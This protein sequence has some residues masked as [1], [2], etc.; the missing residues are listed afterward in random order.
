MR[1]DKLPCE[2][3]NTVH[4]HLL[5]KPHDSIIVAVSGG[6]DS[7]ALITILNS[8]NS[9]KNLNLSLFVAHLNHQLRGKS[10]EEDAQFVKNL[11][12]NLSLPFLLKSVDIQK[13]AD[14]TK[15]SIEE[16]AR[17]ERYKFF[18]ESAQKH[19]ACAIA[20]G[21]TADDNTETI[22]HRILRGT[23]TLGLEG[24]PIKRPL[25]SGSAIQLIRPLLF[26]WRKEVI[27]YLREKEC[28]YRTDASNYE[29]IYLRN[30]IRLELI[31]LLENQYNPNIKNLLMQLGQILN[32]NNEYLISE[33]K[34]IVKAVTK[35]ERECTYIIDTHLLAKQPKILQYFALREILNILQIPLN[36]ITY[37]HYTKILDEITREGKGRHFQLPGKLSLWHEHGMFHF[38][39]DL[40][41]KPCIA[42]S[43]T[44]VKI[45]GNTPVYPLGHLV[46]EIV[47]MQNFSMEAYKKNKTKNE[48]IFNIQSIEMPIT[49]R[50]RKKGDK[51]S[52]LGTN[53]HKKL[54]DIFI[55]K[56]IP[57]KERDTTPIVAM[58]NQPIWVI[59]ICIDNK[60]KVTP[61]TRKFLKLTFH[62]N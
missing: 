62:R 12:K 39:K 8:I 34:N 43:E 30:K 38:Q 9:G 21:H 40:F 54:K 60:V 22:L 28:V 50:G 47:D 56:K 26:T 59:G 36:E 35:E 13:I 57:V 55:D 17:R 48:E 6:P 44:T 5:V 52:P 3:L 32:I 31:P 37:K 29:P 11:S 4:K 41:H 46:S 1:L 23:G 33:A 16:T 42:L 10:S 58:N 25:V 53:G 24:I 7:V 51:I 27:E 14:Q 18:M 19:N 20:I 45:P 49:V 15:R 61:N 2:V